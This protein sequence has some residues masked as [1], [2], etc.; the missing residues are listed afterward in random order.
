MNFTSFHFLG[1]F[2]V[3][4]IIGHWLKNRKQRIFF[5]VASYYFYGVFEPYYLILIFFSTL[6]D[7]VAALGIAARRAGKTSG[8]GRL[9]ERG[10]L[11]A[12]LILN[13]GLLGYFKYTNFGLTILNDVHP[14][15]NT[16]FAWPFLN[17]LLPVGISFYT[18]QSMSYTIDVYR[19]LIPARQSLVDF[20]LYVS[21]FPQLVAGPIVR[22]DTFFNQ[23]DDRLPIGPDDIIV[24]LTR[25]LVGFFRKLV[26]SDNLAPLVTEVFLRHNEHGP[27]DIWIASMGF[28]WQ[29]Y[30]DFAGYTDI[31]RGLARLFGFEFNINFLYPMA[32]R[33]ITDHWQRW[34]ISFTT[35]LRDYIYIPLGGSRGHPVRV[36][37]NIV[38]VWL[39]G[40]V[41]H[42]PAY[43]FV[44]WGLWQAVMQLVHR[45][46]SRTT[47]R[48]FLN[49]RGGLTYNIVSRIFLFFNLNFGFIWF[50]APDM[51][52]ATNMQGRLFGGYQAYDAIREIW[53]WVRGR[54]S[55]EA[56]ILH[57]QGPA[58][59]AAP[60]SQYS[61]FA[62]VLA[63]YFVYEITFNHLQLEYFWK[64]EN[65]SKLI[66]LLILLIFFILVFTPAESPNFAYFQF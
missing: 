41:W 63:L 16:I 49:E 55:L 21:F 2:V 51:Q 20:A 13:L 43:H 54:G 14:L 19:G 24:G 27:L 40:G 60:D 39:F 42:G 8:L 46:Y 7:Y 61:I 56:A 48:A 4:I 32:A 38:L 22:A 6:W 25:I 9:P 12:S 52:V 35:W 64:P 10:W 34:H 66:V 62:G 45:Y 17:I 57:W 11:T 15:G 44:A 5:L 3:T 59:W 58:G 1:F 28:A 47:L 36:Q 33:N 31:A 18:F 37:F 65:R 29:I 23:L 53:N 30:L 50:R 26:L